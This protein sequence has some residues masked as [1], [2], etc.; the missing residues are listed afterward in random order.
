MV[1]YFFIGSKGAVLCDREMET[2]VEWISETVKYYHNF[3]APLISL[4]PNK[5]VLVYFEEPLHYWVLPD[6]EKLTEKAKENIRKYLSRIEEAANCGMVKIYIDKD[7]EYLD[8]NRVKI[9]NPKEI[10][11]EELKRLF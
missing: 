6:L 7:L 8:S 2:E 4:F 3:K 9:N 1:L 11:V 10:K 5:K